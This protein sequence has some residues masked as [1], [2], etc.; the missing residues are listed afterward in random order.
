M[1]SVD[2]PADH[3]PVLEHL[4]EIAG[5]AQIGAYDWLMIPVSLDHEEAVAPSSFCRVFEPEYR[6]GN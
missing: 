4:S 1:F 5:F 2:T 6:V 3:L